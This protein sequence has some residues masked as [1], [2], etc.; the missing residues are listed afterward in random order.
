MCYNEIAKY[1][2]EIRG[3][4]KDCYNLIVKHLEKY[5]GSKVTLTKTIDAEE[6]GLGFDLVVFRAN[7]GRP[8][9]ILST[10]GLYKYKMSGKYKN[11]ELMCYLD[12][13]W[14]LF[15]KEEKFTWIYGLLQQL[16]TAFWI[17]KR[18]LAYGQLYLTEGSNTFCPYTEMSSAILYYP[19]GIDNDM[20]SLKLGMGKKVSFFLVTCATYR[21]YSIVRKMGGLSFVQDY[22]LDDGDL[23]NLVVFNKKDKRE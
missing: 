6:Y 8:Y 17:S 12:K 16:S 15:S 3:K 5:I 1:I 19:T 2:L 13:D 21:E 14:N 18:N 7:L 20:W 4:M 11:I 22:L 9:H 10:V 23:N